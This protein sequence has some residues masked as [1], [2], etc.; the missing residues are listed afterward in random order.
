MTQHEEDLDL[1]QDNYVEPTKMDLLKK[2]A[3]ELG[4]TF[5]EN[6]SERTLEGKIKAREDELAKEQEATQEKEEAPKAALTQ[7]QVVHDNRKRSQLLHRIVVNPVDPRRTQLSGELVVVGNSQL[8]V[9]GK[10]IPFNLETGYHV[11]QIILDDLKNRT[12]TEFYT[13]K[14]ADGNEHTKT[15][16]RKAFIIEVLDSITDEELAA[17]RARQQG[18]AE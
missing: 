8:G 5:K 11:P 14:D 15:R 18:Q 16:Q 17:I 10:F 9:V 12:F 6:I 7:A 13:I 3:K 2:K 4:I 1:A